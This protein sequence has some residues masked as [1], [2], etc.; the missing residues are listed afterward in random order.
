MADGDHAFGGD[1]RR[2]LA[3][4]AAELDAQH[5][6]GLVHV[7]VGLGQGLLALHHRG[8]GLGAQFADHACGDCSHLFLRDEPGRRA[9][10]SKPVR[11]CQAADAALRPAS[12]A[13]GA[14]VQ[15][16]S[17]TSTNSS[18]SALTACTTSLVGVGL[19][20]EHGVGHGARVQRHGLG[21]VVVAGDHVVDAD[22][23]VVGVDHADQRNAQLLGFGDRDLVVADVDDEHRVRQRVHV[24]DAADV[25]LELGQLALEHQALPS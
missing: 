6:F 19:A 7:A 12:D 1:A 8:V 3:G 16:P 17:L 18:P 11:E 25:L 10:R 4:L 24:L 13:A 15:A 23:R 5:L 21:R 22:R 20:F 14:G 9:R 2:G